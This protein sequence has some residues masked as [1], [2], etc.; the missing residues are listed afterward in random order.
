MCNLE[1]LI[2]RKNKAESLPSEILM[3]EKN[4]MAYIDLLACIKGLQTNK[5]KEEYNVLF[6]SLI[7]IEGLE[8]TYKKVPDIF[9]DYCY[10]SLEK[11]AKNNDFKSFL[12]KIS[13]VIELLETKKY[14]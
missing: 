4:F 3:Q 6:L 2:S 10:I 7:L 1:K 8:C 11:S 9:K 13:E 14:K 5:E 12:Y